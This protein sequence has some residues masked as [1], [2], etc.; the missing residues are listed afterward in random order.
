MSA[1]SSNNL[2]KYEYLT[3]KDLGLKP[4]TIEQAG[5]TKGLSKD[6]KREGLFKRLKNIEN[7]QK[8]LIKDDDN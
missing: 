5:F 3:S 2:D 4:K 7:A 1:L 8:G 6:D